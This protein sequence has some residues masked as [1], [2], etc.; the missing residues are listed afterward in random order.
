AHL[1][2]S[3]SLRH[4]VPAAATGAGSDALYKP[5]HWWGDLAFGP[6]RDGISTFRLLSP[7]PLP[8]TPDVDEA[9]RRAVLTTSSPTG[10][11]PRRTC[12]TGSPRGSVPRGDACTAG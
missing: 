11:R 6:D 7:E 10:R 2:R 12:G 1:E 4:L 9:G 8:A 5:L 3:A